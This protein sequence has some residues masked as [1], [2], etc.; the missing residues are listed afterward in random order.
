MTASRILVVDDNEANRDMLSRRLARHGHATV[1]ASGGREALERLGAEAFD[2]VLLDIMMPDMNGYEVLEQLKGDPVL[3][4]IP[5]IMITAMTEMDSIV[6]CI[7][8]G[9]E[10]HLP[11][12]F[13]AT[14]L[15]ARVDA[16]L[17]KKRL[18]DSEQRHAQALERDLEIGRNIQAGFLPESLPPVAGYDIAAHFQPAR[19]VAGDFYDVFTL[20]DTGRIALVVSDVCD[21]G[22]GAAL[23]MAVFR[24]LL[25]VLLRESYAIAPGRTDA[26]HI[27]HAIRVL[28]DYNAH[29]HSSANM[30]AT[31]FFAVLDPSTNGL[32][33]VNA[34]HDAPAIL[35]AGTVLQRLEPT[36]PAVGLLADLTFAAAHVVLQPGDTLLAFT[37]GVSDA[38]GSD[39]TVYGEPRIFGATR[40][41]RSARSII[42]AIDA[43]LSAHTMDAEPF[44]DITLLAVRRLE[45]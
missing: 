18:H 22:V 42:D 40:A 8:M 13:N 41:A 14:L 9:A 4:H 28:S 12:P 34:G 19:Q 21:K 10:D 6:R 39:G 15:K 1:T 24:S 35:R 5:V 30:F 25:R 36:G 20:G 29:T 33:Y 11:K 31:V 7:E 2:L 38:R 37:D 43:D 3:R 23:F 17:A 16:S 44:D 32:T 26:E 27:P 45:P